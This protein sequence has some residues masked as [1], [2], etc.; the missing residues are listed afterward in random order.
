LKS[1]MPKS[2]ANL[3]PIQKA[4]LL[5]YRRG[6]RQGRRQLAA[7]LDYQLEMLQSDY[8][9][10]KRLANEERQRYDEIEA[11]LNTTRDDGPSLN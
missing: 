5:G 9:D 7:S 2:Q 6:I 1:I 11:A 10:I 8:E 3:T 4:F